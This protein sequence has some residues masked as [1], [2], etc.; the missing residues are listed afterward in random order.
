MYWREGLCRLTSRPMSVVNDWQNRMCEMDTFILRRCSNT[1]HCSWVT[2][3]NFSSGL[4]AFCMSCLPE[5]HMCV[6][7]YIKWPVYKY[8]VLFWWMQKRQCCAEF[9][10]VIHFAGPIFD[11]L[12]YIWMAS[13]RCAMICLKVSP[14]CGGCIFWGNMSWKIL[15]G[16]DGEVVVCGDSLWR[17]WRYLS[18]SGRVLGNLSRSLIWSML[19]LQHFLQQEESHPC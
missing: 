16:K 2:W 12:F 6:Y 5:E 19:L 9:L 1:R 7:I 11:C 13:K 3:P 17:R 14:W 18:Q 10:L 4:T 8:E 15:W